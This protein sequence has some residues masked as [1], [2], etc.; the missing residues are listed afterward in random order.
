MLK[1]MYFKP[2][3]LSV[4][5]QSI[6]YKNPARGWYRVY[7]FDV[8]EGINEEEMKHCIDQRE[9]LALVMA[10]I[11]CC[12]TSP[13]SSKMLFNIREI[14]SFFKKNGMEMILRVVYD[15]EG[16]GVLKEPP[17]LSMVLEHIEQVGGII[18]EYSG[19]IH[20][21]QGVFV[22]NWGE[23][24]G[25]RYLNRHI[26]ILAEKLFNATEGSCF[27][28]VRTPVQRRLLESANIPMDKVGLFNDGLFGSD[29]HLGTFGTDT[30]AC[31]RTCKW[32]GERELKYINDSCNSTPNGGEVVFGGSFSPEEVINTIKQMRL[33]YL[34]CVYDEKALDIWKKTP[35]NNTSLYDYIGSHLGYCFLI[36]RVWLKNSIL[37]IAIENTG[38]G[39]L[40]KN[41]EVWLTD[42][43][44]LLRI[45][46]EANP[47]EWSGL[48]ENIICCTVAVK[49]TTKLFLEMK[50]ENGEYIRFINSTEKR[51]FLGTVYAP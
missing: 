49:G 44:E 10:D 32:S 36:K 15:R 22:G 35:F 33:T 27:M 3:N 45:R 13:L 43:A 1:I 48:T 8:N 26:T 14:F 20:T 31:D 38:F 24:H 41:G 29:T 25:S 37:Y 6:N 2:A 47:R 17:L 40:C 4:H 12:R 46:L 7:S 39:S 51:V 50:Y 9:R 30:N 5:T 19:A 34:N 16:K 42:E 28:A 18:K 23:M 21:L 11:G